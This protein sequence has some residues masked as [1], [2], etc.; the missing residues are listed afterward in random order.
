LHAA[1]DIGDDDC[2]APGGAFGI[3]C[4]EDVE[5]HDLSG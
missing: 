3:E 5:L 1:I 4:G 2:G